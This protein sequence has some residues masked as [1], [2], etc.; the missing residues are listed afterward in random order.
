MDK[1]RKCSRRRGHKKRKSRDGIPHVSP[2]L[3]VRRRGMKRTMEPLYQSLSEFRKL[4]SDSL[5]FLVNQKI[6]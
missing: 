3:V 6:N 1:R 4:K 5:L 2:Y